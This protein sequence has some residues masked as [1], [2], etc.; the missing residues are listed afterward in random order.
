CRQGGG[1][2]TTTAREI[3]V[4]GVLRATS[5]PHLPSG[6]SSSSSTNSASLIASPPLTSSRLSLLRRRTTA[7]QQPTGASAP[8]W[9]PTSSCV[10]G[11]RRAP[12]SRAARSESS[13]TTLSGPVRRYGRLHVLTSVQG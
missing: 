3:P 13:L 4:T 10:G 1:E 7:S 6:R 9:T 2:S 5:W 11:S 12:I 8:G